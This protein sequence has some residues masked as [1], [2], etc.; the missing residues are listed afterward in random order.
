MTSHPGND[1]TKPKQLPQN[2]CKGILGK[3]LGH[4]FTHIYNETVEMPRISDILA[5]EMKNLSYNFDYDTTKTYI[6]SICERCGLTIN[7]K[8]E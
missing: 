8:E 6:H 3:L 4:K 2:E 1:M 7:K 5:K